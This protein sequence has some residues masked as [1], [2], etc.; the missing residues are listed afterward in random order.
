MNSKRRNFRITFAVSVVLL[1]AIAFFL[2][3][4]MDNLPGARID[5]TSNKLFTMSPAAARILKDLQVPVQVKLY[6]TPADK[7]TTQMR[8]LERDITEQMRNFEQ[9]ADGMLEFQVFNPQNDE[10]MQ[11]TLADKG[12]RPFQVQ[13]IEKD[14][15]GIKLIWSAITIA[16]KD[17]PEEVLPQV[18]P[19]SLFTLEQDI[20]GPVYRLTREK[21][22]KIALF[23]PKK[24]VDQQLAMMYLQQG[25]Q[26]PEPTE[27][28]AQ[29][30]QLMSQGHYEAVPIELTEASPVPEDADALV[31]MAI[32]QL[33][34]RQ[35][36]EINR[37]LRRGVPV[38]MGMQAHEY[39][40]SPAPSGGW[41]I[42]GQGVETGLESMLAEFGLTVSEDHFM[43]TASEVINLPREVN[44][45][46]LRM[47]TQEPVRLPIQIRV[48][49]AQMDQDSPLVNRIGAIFYLWGTPVLSDADQ[50]ASHDLKATDLIESSDNVWTE[51]WS[52]GPVTGA[53]LSPE[54]KTMTGAQPLAVLVDGIFPDTF[55]GE[56]I[57]AWPQTAD[58][59]AADDPLSQMQATPPP[60]EPQP[61]KLFLIGNAKMFDDNILAA[62]QNA[63]LLLNAV[64]FLAGSREL[65]DIR[66]KTL[67]QRVIKPVE[68]N[69]KMVWRFVAVLLVPI[70]IAVFGITRAAMR[71]KRASRYR[72]AITHSTHSV[73]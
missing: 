62:G 31:V 37:T 16:Y 61:G 60:V 15:M 14:E 32:S 52:D 27:Q 41:T 26:P 53:M 47:Q 55:E 70:I 39:G 45:G 54:G 66:S 33:N 21:A 7:M 35:V 22:P 57:P 46:G 28:Y 69:Q 9:V 40:Y 42:A 30:S 71:R 36:Y 23:G 8:N 11:K 2:V 13:S 43:D 59:A 29:L 38:I 24:P 1:T 67:T 19:Q 48:T 44:L 73:G 49:E 72:E 58:P 17:K 3:S 34:P 4:V 65:L 10:D 6:I 5:M 18:L 63:L 20:I 64:D 25:M 51:P 68:A 56:E 50:L 12:I